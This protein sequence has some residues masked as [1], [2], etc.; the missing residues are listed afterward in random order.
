MCDIIISFHLGNEAYVIQMPDIA[1]EEIPVNKRPI[2][3]SLLQGQITLTQVLS[4]HFLD[5]TPKAHILCQN[6]LEIEIRER[7]DDG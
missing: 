5:F 3:R 4:K 7:G 6:L 2:Y 1:A